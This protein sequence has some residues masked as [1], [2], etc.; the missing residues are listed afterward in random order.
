MTENNIKRVVPLPQH[1]H[2][3]L[4]SGGQ[5][6]GRALQE[7]VHIEALAAGWQLIVQLAHV[8]SVRIDVDQ[9]KVCLGNVQHVQIVGQ[10]LG[11]LALASGHRSLDNDYLN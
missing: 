8:V 11:K 6:V 5:C 3:H 1:V 2:S 4:E 7:I 9:I 10:L